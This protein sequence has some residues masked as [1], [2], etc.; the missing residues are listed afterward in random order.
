MVQATP[1]TQ[2]A[3]E[4]SGLPSLTGGASGGP[5]YTRLRFLMSR[6]FHCRPEGAATKQ[7]TASPLENSD[8]GKL[9][10]LSAHGKLAPRELYSRSGLTL[11][12]SASEGPQ[13]ISSLTLREYPSAL[14]RLS[15]VRVE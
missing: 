2:S 11:T 9:A 5:G 8:D 7:P 6:G 14:Q 12:Q 10:W 4:G 3:S 1:L 13:P 15:L